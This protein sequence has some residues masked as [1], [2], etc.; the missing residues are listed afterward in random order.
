M[1]W[2]EA[3][4]VKPPVE[5]DRLELESLERGKTH[6]LALGLLEDAA[7]RSMRLPLLV[8][9]GSEDGPVVG[10]TAAVHGN[11]LNG[12][13][14]IHRLMHRID[15]TVLRGTVVSAPILNL[16]GYL[17]HQRVF[18]DGEDLNRIMPGR[19]DGNE[20]QIYASRL[21]DRLIRHFDY[22]IDLHTASF[23]RANALY[24]RAN[25]HRTIT[26]RLARLIGAQILIHNE[27]GDGTLRGAAAAMGIPSITIEVGDPHIFDAVLIRTSRIGVR[28]VLEDL[29]MLD[30]DEEVSGSPAIECIRSYWLYTDTGGL[31]DVVP[32]I[33]EFVEQGQVIAHLSDPWG[34][35]LRT[36]RAKERAI[37]VGR[38]T[39]PVAH[40]GARI[41]H[42]GI[43][44]PGGRLS[45]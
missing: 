23:G 11:E 30:P 39:N 28:D 36:Y 9:R 32:G 19:P 3:F 1:D 41:A 10:V 6:R 17:R 27:P 26:A 16:P 12:I 15:A 33:A 40:A 18:R 4:P 7:S 25:M 5:I 22:L 2:I 42:L 38:S 21:I 13:P 14:T 31:L 35:V 20:S 34:Q 45:F 37:V 24:V 29:G 43:E 44:A 8:A